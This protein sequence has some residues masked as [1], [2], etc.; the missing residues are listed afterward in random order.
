[1]NTTA[2]AAPTVGSYYDID[3][4]DL[5]NKWQSGVLPN[6]GVQLR[7]TRTSNNWNV[8]ASSENLNAAWRPQLVVDGAAP[9]IP[10]SFW[11]EASWVG[12]QGNWGFLTTSST[13]VNYSWIIAAFRAQ[14]GDVAAIQNIQCQSGLLSPPVCLGEVGYGTYGPRTRTAVEG[15]IRDYQRGARK[16]LPIGWKFQ[17]LQTTVNG[18]PVITTDNGIDYYRWY[19]AL[20]ATDGVP[21]WIVAG[22]VDANTGAFTEQYFR[23]DA[24]KQVEWA[25]YANIITSVDQATDRTVRAGV[26]VDAVTSTLNT[27]LLNLSAIPSQAI[28]AIAAVESGGVNFDNEFVSYDY[29]HG[30]FQLTF[31]GLWNE[32]PLIQNPTKYLQNDWD[33]RGIASRIILPPCRSIASMLYYNCYTGAGI[34]SADTRVSKPYRAYAGDPATAIYKQYANSRQSIYANVL[35]GMTVLSTKYAT[36]SGVIGNHAPWDCSNPPRNCVVGP[37]PSRTRYVVSADEMKIIAAIKAFNAIKPTRPICPYYLN[38]PNLYLTPVAGKLSTISSI[39]NV[40][41]YDDSSSQLSAKMIAV[42]SSRTQLEICSPGTLQIIDETGAITGGIGSSFVGNVPLAFYRD[43]GKAAEVLLPNS[44]YKYQVIGTDAG[45]YSFYIRNT[46][47]DII[48]NVVL[49]NIP[50]S[51]GEIHTFQVDWQT[52]AQGGLGVSIA[53]DRK[54]DGQQID[55]FTVGATTNGIPGDANRDGR[56]DC[57]DMSIVK[58]SFGRR[59]GSAGFDPRADLNGDG[60]VDIRDVTLVSRYLPVGTKCS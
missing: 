34:I 43:D 21:G 8:F 11:A 24:A 22:K 7:P 30:A 51:L 4:T 3:I 18:A 26:I 2:L 39:F 48:S 47:P 49:S 27:N 56:V 15:H 20:D 25:N 33:N 41:P 29:G 12:S 37:A 32:E 9:Q 13:P 58:A 40:S 54:G 23:Y 17:V 6:F 57:I 36:V 55:R 52:I 10:D 50:L 60:V 59:V 16:I 46:T 38:N 44:A 28:L 35:D 42:E 1:L 31:K 14:Y 45:S 19:K 53:I 5:Y